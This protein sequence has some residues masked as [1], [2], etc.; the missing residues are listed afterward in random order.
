MDQPNLPTIEAMV[1]ALPESAG[2][3]LYGMVDVLNATCT[4]WQELVGEAPNGPVLRTR[5][6]GPTRAPFRCGNDIPVQPAIG[7][8]EEPLA[9]IVIVPEL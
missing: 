1:V 9:D 4:L 8:D 5:I 3:A 7:I 2:S 6:I